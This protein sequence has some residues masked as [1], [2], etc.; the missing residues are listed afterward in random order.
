M[1]DVDVNYLDAGKTLAFQTEY[2]DVRAASYEE[3]AHRHVH[4]SGGHHH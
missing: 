1:A 2:V 3:L 4:G